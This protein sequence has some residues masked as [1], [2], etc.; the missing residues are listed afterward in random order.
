MDKKQASGGE[1]CHLESGLRTR[2]GPRSSGQITFA[3]SL[4]GYTV[5]NGIDDILGVVSGGKGGE[6]HET[7]NTLKAG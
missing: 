2:F 3:F 4:Q 7:K 6:P 5:N 1:V